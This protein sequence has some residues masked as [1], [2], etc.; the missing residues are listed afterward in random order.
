[1]RIFIVED[2]TKTRNGLQKLI[3]KLGGSYEIAGTADNGEDGLQ[4]IRRVDPDLVIADIKMPRMD[5]LTMIEKLKEEHRRQQVVLLSGYADFQYAQKAIRCGVAEYLLK[6]ITVDDLV[7]VL[8]RAQSRVQEQIL[9]LYNKLTPEALVRELLSGQVKNRAAIFAAFNQKFNFSLA[10]GNPLLVALL[11]LAD[12]GEPE[13]IERYRAHFSEVLSLWPQVKGTLVE[14]ESSVDFV[15]VLAGLPDSATGR[16]FFKKF[17][18]ACGEHDGAV[19]VKE[20]RAP[21]LIAESIK[22]LRKRLELAK[23]TEEKIIDKDT[24]LPRPAAAFVYPEKLEMECARSIYD[25]DRR[26][27]EA[28]IQK[29]AQ[30]CR[31]ECRS[32]E[33]INEAFLRFSS[34]V[35]DVLKENNPQRYS[36]INKGFIFHLISSS[37]TWNE[38][39]HPLEI[40][41]GLGSKGDTSHTKPYSLVV[42]KVLNFIDHHYAEDFSLDE[43]AE[44]LHVTSEYLSSLFGREVGESYK[45][46]LTRY[47]VGKAKELI[48]TTNLKNYE[49]AYKVGYRNPRYFCSVFKKITGA[50]P[51]EYARMFS[52]MIDTRQSE[53]KRG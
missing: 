7:A 28:L 12:S 38:L 43:L 42:Q 48:L 6:P 30:T 15:A 29:F 26:T 33:E 41:E 16:S 11:H 20:I 25:R 8:N 53:E 47:R 9:T 27:F 52:H 37:V 14:L 3:E 22:P 4:E 44:S 1:M 49:I 24:C 13:A 17:F 2:E 51:G 40:L 10:A 39:L 23:L 35:L 36:Q 34:S 19:S 5:G 50:S 18:T 31:R 45:R 21:E 32:P 46:F